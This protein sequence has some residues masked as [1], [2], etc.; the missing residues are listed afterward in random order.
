MSCAFN[1]RIVRFGTWFTP[2]LE[3]SF[4][5]GCKETRTDLH[6]AETSWLPPH[7]ALFYLPKILVPNLTTETN[8]QAPVKNRRQSNQAIAGHC[9]RDLS[10]PVVSCRSVGGWG[11]VIGCWGWALAAAPWGVTAEGRGAAASEAATRTRCRHCRWKV[12]FGPALKSWTHCIDNG[13]ILHQ[14]WVKDRD[15][16]KKYKFL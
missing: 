7:R 4:I 1:L 14:M 8:Y 11:L 15:N 10:C 6:L 2:L 3:G 5:A 13:V 16:P 12:W 9:S